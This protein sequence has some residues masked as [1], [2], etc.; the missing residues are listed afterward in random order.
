MAVRLGKFCGNGPG[1]W[2][3]VRQAYDLWHAERQLRS[4]LEKIPG[5]GVAA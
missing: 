5:R 3:P 1:L 2:L 4:E